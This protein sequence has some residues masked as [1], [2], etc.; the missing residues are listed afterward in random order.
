MLKYAACLVY[1]FSLV[2]FLGLT[3]LALASVYR[4]GLGKLFIVIP[5]EHLLASTRWPRAS[6][7]TPV[8]CCCSLSRPA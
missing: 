4:G 6:T 2:A 3:A 7:A 1:T 5:D 8:A